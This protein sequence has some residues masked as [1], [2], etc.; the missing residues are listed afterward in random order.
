MKNL[1][2]KVKMPGSKSK[3]KNKNSN[4]ADSNSETNSKED[5]K[6]GACSSTKEEDVSKTENPET[7]KNIEEIASVS[8][9]NDIKDLNTIKDLTLTDPGH[10]E[11]NILVPVSNVESKDE[12]AI[13]MNSVTHPEGTSDSPKIESAPIESNESVIKD[14]DNVKSVP[15]TQ[16]LDQEGA[17]ILETSSK[18]TVADKTKSLTKLLNEASVSNEEPSALSRSNIDIR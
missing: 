3:Q 11:E 17:A 18:T 2:K 13:E 7:S 6:D 8:N 1:L 14:S 15:T 12:T 5:S 4:N 16:S 10:C 9:K